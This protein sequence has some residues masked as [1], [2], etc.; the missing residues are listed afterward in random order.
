MIDILVSDK[1]MIYDKPK[2]EKGIKAEILNTSAFLHELLYQAVKCPD[3]KIKEC[4]N[5]IGIKNLQLFLG[6]F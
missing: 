1:V 6:K 5:D 4:L 2:F 3:D